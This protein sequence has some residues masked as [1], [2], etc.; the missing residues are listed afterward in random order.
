MR[1][2][3]WVSS[4]NTWVL[5]PKFSRSTVFRVYV[6]ATGSIRFSGTVTGTVGTSGARPF[7]DSSSPAMML[8][9]FRPVELGS[10]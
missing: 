5:A 6:P 3:V 4:R 9:R 7:T 1:D 2:P 8:L 10:L